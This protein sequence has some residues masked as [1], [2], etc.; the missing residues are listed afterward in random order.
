MK[1]EYKPERFR[2]I[3][4]LMGFTNTEVQLNMFNLSSNTY[5]KHVKIDRWGLPGTNPSFNRVELL[6]EAL[7]IPIQ[8]FYLESI[9]VTI[10]LDKYP[11]VY[12][13]H[14]LVVDINESIS[15]ILNV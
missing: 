3:K 12:T 15:F 14:I 4:L 10:S 9:E 6:A 8:F 2:L 13:V 7:S 11:T 1:L 5:V